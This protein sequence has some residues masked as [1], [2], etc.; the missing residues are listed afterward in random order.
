MPS[1]V[2]GSLPFY[3]ILILG[4]ILPSYAN[5]AIQILS[6]FPKRVRSQLVFKQL[7][8]FVIKLSMNLGEG[9]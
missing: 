4:T 3:A 5:Q 8:N 2:F 9:F 7:S 6:Q 1:L